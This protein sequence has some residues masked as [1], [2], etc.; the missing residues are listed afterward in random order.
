MSSVKT[1]ASVDRYKARET[2][3]D[4]VFAIHEEVLKGDLD[5]IRLVTLYED[6]P[7]DPIQKP[8]LKNIVTYDRRGTQTVGELSESLA[9]KRRFQNLIQKI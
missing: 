6:Y 5:E 4:L 7:R 9:F 8:S 2:D 3:F 1:R